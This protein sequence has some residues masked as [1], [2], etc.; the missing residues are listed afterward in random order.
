MREG[1]MP[2]VREILHPDG[3]PSPPG[4]IYGLK[5]T[6]G[7]RIELQGEPPEGILTGFSADMPVQM[8]WALS[9]MLG[10]LGK[11]G[12]RPDDTVAVTMHVSN[13]NPYRDPTVQKALGEVWRR[14]FGRRYYPTKL[15]EQTPESMAID[16]RVPIIT[17]SG[18]ALV[19]APAAMSEPPT[20][21]LAGQNGFNDKWKIE[22]DIVRQT[23]LALRKL[24]AVLQSGGASFQTVKDLCLRLYANPDLFAEHEL[25][26][27]EVV[28]EV[29]GKLAAERL[30]IYPATGFF[31]PDAVVEMDGYA[32]IS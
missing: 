3:W 23:E 26:I 8:D 11:V 16:G 29:G 9:H 15:I 31:E 30:T 18:T 24:E 7:R 25:Q 13:V 1:M 22:G 6:G 17:V 19:P 14:Y 2:V 27:R 21:W 32:R 10:E 5:T 28:A 12:G 20:I 4:F